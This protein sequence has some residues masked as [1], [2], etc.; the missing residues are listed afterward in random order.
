MSETYQMNA[1]RDIDEVVLSLTDGPREPLYAPLPTLLP[2]SPQFILPPTPPVVLSQ[3]E[4]FDYGID[5]E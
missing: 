4:L 2:S 3:A 5:F 1:D